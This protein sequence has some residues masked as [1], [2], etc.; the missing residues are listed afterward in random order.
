MLHNQFVHAL[1]AARTTCGRRNLE[2]LTVAYRGARIY[3]A[4]PMRLPRRCLATSN[5]QRLP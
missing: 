1:T 5:R 2:F 4:V 3:P